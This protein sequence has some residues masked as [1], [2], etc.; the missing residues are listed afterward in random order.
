MKGDGVSVLALIVVASFVIDRV[1]SG[2][3]FV[4]SLAHI[5]PDPERADSVTKRAGAE[6]M[7]KLVYFILAGLLVVAVLV[8]FPD[9]RILK[10]M[11]VQGITPI[12]DKL[13]T[14]LLLVGGAERLSQFIQTPGSGQ[15][16]ESKP[17]PPLPP[18][19][20]EGTLMLIRS[21]EQTRQLRTTRAGI[22]SS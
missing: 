18:I 19:R 1:V 3:L 12:L 8:Y 11:G 5:V 22:P 13:V 16:S 20:I 10:A 17:E 9:V 21:S 7:Y 4:A 6:K 2:V 14:G 15:K